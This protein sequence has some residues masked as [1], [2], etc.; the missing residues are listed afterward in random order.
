MSTTI[1]DHETGVRPEVVSRL[2]PSAA[3]SKPGR[4]NAEE[5]AVVRRYN[6][7]LYRLANGKGS[8]SEELS[9][10]TGLTPWSIERR[11]YRAEKNCSENELNAES[12]VLSRR[13]RGYMS[14]RYA[15]MSDPAVKSFVRGVCQVE[16]N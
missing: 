8:V 3:R 16:R 10:V 15:N 13:D 5:L 9:V 6:L 2:A 12:G 14:A 11:C 4:P 7:A 1:N